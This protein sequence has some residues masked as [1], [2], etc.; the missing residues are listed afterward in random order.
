MRTNLEYLVLDALEHSDDG[1][2]SGNLF[3]HLRDQKLQTSQATLGR[4][5]RLL[6]HQKLTAKVSNKGRVLTAA[7]RRHLEELRHQE[8]LRRWAEG[9]LKEIKSA[10]QSEYLQ[11]LHALRLLEGHL[12]RLAAEHASKDHV[13]LMR[14][15]LEEHQKEME[16][17]TRGKDQGLEFHDLVAAAAGNRF[18]QTAI[19]MIWNWIKP[20][21]D[22]WADADVLTG[23][24][25]YPDHLRVFKAIIA[26][27]G[28]GAELAMHSHYD[29][30]IE[31]VRKHFVENL[32]VSLGPA[33]GPEEVPAAS[34]PARAD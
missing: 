20:I 29:L 26:H 15:T 5:L 31:S 2:G 3:L 11:G 25:S 19:S 12:A 17:R 22:L 16:S 4:V 13:A 27:D 10:T 1:I 9:V 28:G 23:Q 21:Q 32:P 30:F 8:G 14:R 24:S 34:S 6:D 18:L 7:G 33:G